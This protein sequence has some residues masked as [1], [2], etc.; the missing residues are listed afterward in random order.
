VS[1]QAQV[2]VSLETPPGQ[3]NAQMAG[4]VSAR[5]RAGMR[6]LAIGTALLVALSAPLADF[7]LE[8][9]DLDHRGHLYA[10][11]VASRLVN[12]EGATHALARRETQ[13]AQL[14]IDQAQSQHN[15]EDVAQ[16]ELWWPDGAPML[17]SAVVHAKKVWPLVWVK[18]PV[19]LLGKQIATVRAAVVEP[20]LLERDLL[21]VGVFGALG[22]VLG[23]ALYFFPLRL[24]REEDLVQLFARRSIRAEEEERV[25]LSRELHDG[26]GQTLG[27][28]AVAV[29]RL[30][31]RLGPTP[32]ASETGRLIDAALDELRNI[33]LGLRPTLLDDLGLG[34]AVKALAGQAERAGVAT[35]ASIGELPRLDPEMELAIFRLAQEGI[36]NMVQHAQAKSLRLSLSREKDSVVLDM[37]DDGK[38]FSTSSGMGLG[39]V[40]ARER[41]ASLSGTFSVESAAGKGTRLRAVL[42]IRKAK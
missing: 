15:A 42:P 19:V 33:T 6:P 9:H 16:L 30:T 10:A 34:S 29:V 17:T 39:L 41:A 24:F 18:E 3:S 25:R 12:L 40:G 28:A 22:M 36:S 2:T 31:A 20:E 13:L 5:F 35:T 38:G 1:T 4:L 32:E 27:T 23:L 7:L 21:L 8:T 37:Q 11:E 14:L 26:M